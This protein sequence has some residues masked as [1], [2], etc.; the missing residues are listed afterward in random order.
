MLKILTIIG[1]RPQIIKSAALS[2]AIRNRFSDKIREIIVHTG[3][4]YDHNMSDVFIHEL[5]IPEPNYNLAVGSGQHG[6]Q[7][8][9]MLTGIEQVLLCEK[10]DICIL[11]GDTNSTLAGAI[12]A[13]K[14]HIPVAH[15][16]AGLR[17]FDK[18][19][20][21]E[22][23]R[24]VCDHC[25]TFLFTPTFTAIDNLQR[26]GF[27]TDTSP[28]F[29]INNPAI[30]HSG[31][32]MYDNTL[33][34]SKLTENKMQII[35]TLD[36]HN[37][38]FI[39]C[40]IHRPHNTDNLFQLKNILRGISEL[41]DE[42]NTRCIIPL[43][44]RTTKI[45]QQASDDFF[46]PYLNKKIPLLTIIPPV[47]F[48]EMTCLEKHAAIIITDS[49]GVQKEAYFLNKPCVILRKETEWVEIIN[50]GAGALADT[51]PI[52]IKHLAMRFMENPPSHFPPVFGN[53]KAAETI[54]NI[55]VEQI[56]LK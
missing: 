21:E 38:P 11:F 30:F 10:P 45:M 48:L 55:L 13:S 3:Q 8:A 31:D 36:L 20:P 4:H 42:T 6:D 16:E 17:S 43:H 12:A 41:A 50:A 2:R 32:I 33:Y 47:S 44:P 24:I 51:D 23:N 1:A 52:K 14:L 18:T 27:Q 46:E 39:L 15:I 22:I 35:E 49:G 28:P 56:S 25:S 53:G 5:E 37:K 9:G 7:T 54:C 40:T 26:E 34:F 29:N 19:M